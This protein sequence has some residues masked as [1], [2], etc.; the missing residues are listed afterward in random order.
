MGPDG[1]PDFMKAIAFLI[2]FSIA[3]CLGADPGWA[4][5]G[6]PGRKPPQ[7][8]PEVIDLNFTEAA[9]ETAGS[10]QTG[11]ERA[12]SHRWIFWT[13][14]GALVSAGGVGWYLHQEQDEEPSVSRNDRIFTDERP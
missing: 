4:A 2:T 8:K 5:N 12:D 11:S 1:R 3:L 6:R 13:V 10:A 14:G 9:E 7:P